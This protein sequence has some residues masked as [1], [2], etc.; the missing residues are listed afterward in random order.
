MRI[1]AVLLL[2]G[3]VTGTSILPNEFSAD[4]N[5]TNSFP[6]PSSAELRLQAYKQRQKLQRESLAANLPFRS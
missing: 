4:T 1:L 6:A 3:I 5:S 2:V